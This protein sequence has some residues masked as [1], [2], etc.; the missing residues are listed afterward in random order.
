MRWPWVLG[1]AALGTLPSTSFTRAPNDDPFTWP[2]LRRGLRQRQRRDRHLHRFMQHAAFQ[3]ERLYSEFEQ[4]KHLPNESAR[5]RASLEYAEHTISDRATRIMYP[6]VSNTEE[7]NSF[8]RQYGCT[9]WTDEAMYEIVSR[10]PIVQY[11]AG[12]GQ[13][14]LEAAQ[15]GADVVALDDGRGPALEGQQ[16]VYPVRRVET[17]ALALYRPR[18]LLLVYPQRDTAEQALASHFGETIIYIGEGRGGANASESFFDTLSRHYDVERRVDVHP[19]AGGLEKMFVLRRRE[20]T[21]ER[22]ALMGKV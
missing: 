12:A 9:A 3:L 7:R 1:A 2:E 17:K 14:A 16:P 4:R 6:G 20:E 10:S 15:R 11:N 18:T 22:A 21:E 8:L 5:F 13:W 19:F